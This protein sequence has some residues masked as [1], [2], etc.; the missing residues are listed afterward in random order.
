[1]NQKRSWPGV[2]NR[3]S[4]RWSLMVIRPKSMATVVDVLP[5]T[6]SSTPM[7][8]RLS[9]S[10][11]CSGCT[12]LTAPTS[13]VLPAPNPPATTILNAA[14]TLS[15]E[16]SECT[17]TMQHLLQQFGARLITWAQGRHHGDP[18][19][20][21]EVGQQDADHTERQCGR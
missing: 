1:M 17:E 4:T 19:P 8:A 9:A 15:A 14:S 11:V 18:T 6:G 21:D 20:L 7:P 5:S 2:P 3:Y 10:S 16:T 12:S 13:V